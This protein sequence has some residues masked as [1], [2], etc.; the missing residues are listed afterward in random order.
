MVKGA[1]DFQTRGD[2][3][4]LESGYYRPDADDGVGMTKIQQKHGGQ[5]EAQFGTQNPDDIRDAIYEAMKRPD[6]IT[7]NLG[8]GT[9]YYK[10]FEEADRP[11]RVSTSNNGFTL[12]AHP[13]ADA[14]I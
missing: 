2:V 4:W 8:G 1:D 13:D 9:R 10:H 14:P 11:V 7:Q 6:D 3:Q 12:S 5:F